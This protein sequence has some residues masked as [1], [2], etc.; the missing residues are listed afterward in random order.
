[1]KTRLVLV[2]SA[3]GSRIGYRAAVA[4]TPGIAS[5]TSDFDISI[6]GIDV[7]NG[8]G[9]AT[10]ESGMGDVAIAFGPNSNAISEGGLGDFASAFSTGSS[11]AIAIAGS[12]DVGASGNNFDYASAVGNNANAF[13]GHPLA[14]DI[15]PNATPSSFDS[16]SD[17]GG[18][19]TNGIS[20]A[21]AGFN[22][23]FDSANAIGETGGAT[24]GLSP[25]SDVPADL[26]PPPSLATSSSPPARSAEPLPEA[27]PRASV[28]AA[29]LPLSTTCSAR[30]AAP[31]WPAWAI[32][33]TSPAPSATIYPPTRSEP[34]SSP[35]FAVLLTALMPAATCGTAALRRCRQPRR[36]V[37][38]NAAR[39]R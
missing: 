29:T 32:I 19:G 2:G 21:L 30:R 12:Q 10:A 15:F 37:R 39:I 7:F 31:L 8:G 14:A 16:A 17:F 36:S 23:S 22:G 3:S 25:N 26:T 33:S 27:V 5:A 38:A 1:M 11:G 28:A 13:A 20:V 35:T 4:A 9:S 6:D 24:A 34:T 18:D